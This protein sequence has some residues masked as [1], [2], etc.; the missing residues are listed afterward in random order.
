LSTR[1]D[2]RIAAA[3]K[4]KHLADL[5]APATSGANDRFDACGRPTALEFRTWPNLKRHLANGTRSASLALIDA[6][7]VPFVYA[8]LN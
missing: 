4:A 1:F 3:A 6:S 7:I 2:E 5:S 8:V